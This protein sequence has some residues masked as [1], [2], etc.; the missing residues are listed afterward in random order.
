MQFFHLTVEEF[1]KIKQFQD[2]KCAICQRP[3]KQPNVDHRHTDGL[4]R[5]LLCMTCNKGLGYLKDNVENLLRTISYLAN[6]PAV[7]ALGEE[8][9]GE[10]KVGTYAKAPKK[11]ATP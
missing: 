11:E 10:L 8:R 5:G 6:P 4:I 3:M 2:S 9:F 7:Q 1:E